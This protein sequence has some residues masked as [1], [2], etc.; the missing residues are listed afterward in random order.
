M[1]TR[2]LD[3][4]TQSD[5]A[6]ALIQQMQGRL[7]DWAAY[8]SDP[9]AYWADLTAAEMIRQMTNFNASADASWLFTA[10]GAALEDLV[11]Q[12]GLTRQ[13]DETDAALRTRAVAQFASRAVGTPDAVRVDARA[14]DERVAS[15]TFRPDRAQNEIDVWIT[16]HTTEAAPDD[17]APPA[18]LRTVVQDYLN[19]DVRKLIWVDYAVQA[20]TITK[21]DVDGRITYAHGTVSPQAAV[22]A[23]LAD[24]MRAH[25]ALNTRVSVSGLAAACWVAGVVDVDLTAPAN[26]LARAI[27]TAYLGSIGTLTYHEE[28]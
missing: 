4:P 20:P 19:A 2:L 9:G 25:R 6:A 8:D 11:S 10:A 28:S 22:E 23:A 7:P 13:T 27:D 21:Y 17:I 15:V 1:T 3:I 5:L 24:W 14:A 16:R 12:F 26:D 18:D